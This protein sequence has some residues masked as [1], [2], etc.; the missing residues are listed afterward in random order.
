VTAQ[1]LVIFPKYVRPRYQWVKGR[2]PKHP[3]RIKPSTDSNTC[4]PCSAVMCPCKS[5]RLVSR[6]HHR[7]PYIRRPGSAHQ[8]TRRCCAPCKAEEVFGQCF[9]GVNQCTGVQTWL[10]LASP[11]AGIAITSSVTMHHTASRALV[12]EWHIVTC[13]VFEVLL[14]W[15]VAKAEYRH[16]QSI[17]PRLAVASC[18]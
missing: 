2:K 11:R 12:A 15:S 4:T 8:F 18:W 17:W 14:V 10:R 1:G 7:F 16:C 3:P 13:H 6:S 5:L 9:A